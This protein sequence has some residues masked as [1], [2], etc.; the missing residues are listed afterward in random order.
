MTGSR[1]LHV[2]PILAAAIGLLLLGAG[3]WGSWVIRDTGRASDR[4]ASDDSPTPVREQLLNEIL[5]IFHGDWKP[6]YG[7]PIASDKP[8]SQ[9]MDLHDKACRSQAPEAIAAC[10]K[11]IE[12]NKNDKVAYAMRAWRHRNQGDLAK[13]IEDYGEA[14]RCGA[15]QC[16][17]VRA[18]VYM[19]KGEYGKAI[20]DCTQAINA[21]TDI[22]DRTG[23]R[24]KAYLYRA[25]AYALNGESQSC[26]DD[27]K[28]YAEIIDEE[29]RQR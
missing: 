16:L 23:H 7:P 3:A 11:S 9:E 2:H 24:R 12:H 28:R 26:D 19:R 8:F 18:A 14:I 10:T 20:E 27:L 1:A 25:I 13:A 21:L 5:C 6:P 17:I 29:R 4:L 15:T 22:R